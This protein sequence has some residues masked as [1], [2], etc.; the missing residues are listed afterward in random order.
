MRQEHLS[1][2][3]WQDAASTVALLMTS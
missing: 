2:R 1:T 3:L